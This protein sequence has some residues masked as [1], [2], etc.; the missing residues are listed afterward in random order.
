M[1]KDDK[2]KTVTLYVHLVRRIRDGN[3]VGAIII[4]QSQISKTIHTNDANIGGYFGNYNF[5]F[6]VGSFRPGH[7][8]HFNHRCRPGRHKYHTCGC[9][10]HWCAH[11][12]PG[13]DGDDHLD[14]A[15]D[16]I[17]SQD[18]LEIKKG[19]HSDIDPKVYGSGGNPYGALKDGNYPHCPKTGGRIFGDGPAEPPGGRRVFQ[20]TAVFPQIVTILIRK[21]CRLFTVCS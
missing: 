9:D 21:C 1:D 20:K 8:T 4:Q 18:E 6:Y 7:T 17:S 16:L 19:I 12:V 15:F 10:G 5:E 14:F 13:S 3:P 2:E 11:A